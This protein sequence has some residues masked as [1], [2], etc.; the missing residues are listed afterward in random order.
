MRTGLFISAVSHF[1]LVALALLGT[2]R[3]L[4]NTKL[5]TIEVDLVRDEQAEPEP[6][7][8][9]E[10][11]PEKKPP[12]KTAEWNPFPSSA[13]AA[14]AR[15]PASETTPTQ[16]QQKQ[17][18]Q[19]AQAPQQPQKEPQP[20]KVPTPQTPPAEQPGQQTPAPERPTQ[21]ALATP[22]PPPAEPPVQ[23]SPWIFD[24]MNIPALMNIPNGGPQAEFDSE[25][26]TTANLSSDDR[27]AFKQHLKRC[28]KLPGGVSDNTRVTL[29]IFLKRDGG[30]ASEPVLIEG[31]ASSDGP[32][33]MQAAIRSVKEC[34]PFA[35]LPADRYRE[36]KALDVTFSPKDVAGG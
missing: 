19:Q 30:L 15:P 8:L 13:S 14:P 1:A 2:P 20:Q 9:K 12:E 31:S 7:P 34:Q 23:Q 10:K 27:S 5:E 21:Q 29:R 16:R 33:L 17:P 36:W 6:E 22:T 28:L 4:E 25:A 11:E 32:R 3:L 35:F 18:P 24:P 26:T